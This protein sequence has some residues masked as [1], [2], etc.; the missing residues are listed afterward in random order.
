MLFPT[1]TLDL[2][3]SNVAQKLK[4][5]VFCVYI[6]AAFWENNFE[7][8]YSDHKQDDNASTNYCDVRSLRPHSLLCYVYDFFWFGLWIMEIEAV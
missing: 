6:V 5:V 3:G 1:L 2:L 8:I 4:C 7:K